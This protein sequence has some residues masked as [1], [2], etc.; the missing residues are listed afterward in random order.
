MPDEVITAD[1]AGF[2]VG[3][4][5]GERAHVPDTSAEMET[6]HVS[7]YTLDLLDSVREE[8]NASDNEAVVRMLLR[9]W[10]LSHERPE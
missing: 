5:T 2:H 3:E 9:H 4:P 1:A 6:L 8:I 10:A 7:K